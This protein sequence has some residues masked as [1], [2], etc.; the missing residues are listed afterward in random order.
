MDQQIGQMIAGDRIAVQKKV[1]GKGEHGHRAQDGGAPY[2]ILDVGGGDRP[3]HDM[4]VVENIGKIIKEK[5]RF[6]GVAV[7][8]KAAEAKE[9]ENHYILR[10]LSERIMR[11]RCPR[12]YSK[13]MLSVQPFSRLLFPAQQVEQPTLFPL[14]WVFPQKS[15]SCWGEAVRISRSS[16]FPKGRSIYSGMIISNS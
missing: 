3:H 11:H 16:F 9:E 12:W 1:Q 10:C 6:Q 4:G 8:G 5:G 13:K 7:Y 14:E 2:D 15:V